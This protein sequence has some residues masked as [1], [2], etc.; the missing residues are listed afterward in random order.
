MKALWIVTLISSSFGALALLVSLASAKG[1][2]QEAAGAA[3]ACAMAIIPYVFTRA[4]EAMSARS[5]QQ[6]VQ[7][8]IRAIESLKSDRA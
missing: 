6:D 3:I 2:P 8:V 7:E 5:R 1:A 4:I